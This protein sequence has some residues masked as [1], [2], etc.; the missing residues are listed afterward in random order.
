MV[1]SFI[2][3]RHSYR[4]TIAFVRLSVYHTRTCVE[5]AKRIEKLFNS[6]VATLFE[7][8]YEISWRNSDELY[9][10]RRR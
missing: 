1:G 9:P 2:V 10:R 8:F 6:Q 3:V 4:T 7:I 5:M